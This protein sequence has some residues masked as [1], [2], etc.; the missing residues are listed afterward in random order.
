[1][2]IQ[3]YEN[4]VNSRSNEQIMRLK[5]NETHEIPIDFSDEFAMKSNITGN[6]STRRQKNTKLFVRTTFTRAKCTAIIQ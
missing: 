6:K 4:E 5:R 3:I 2:S 1:M